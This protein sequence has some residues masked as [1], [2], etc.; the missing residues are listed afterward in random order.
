MFDVRPGEGSRA[1]RASGALFAILAGYTISETARDS[2]FLAT[3][4]AKQLALAYLAIAAIA[5]LALLANGWVVRRL[6]RRSA[7]IVTLLVAATGTS[8]FYVLPRTASAG[9]ALY[10]WTGL[11][12]TI[13]VVQ[14]WLLASTRFTSAEAKRLYGLIA[15][16]GAVGTLAG[17]LLAW[18]LL[19]ELE[20]EGL[21]LVASVFYV[22]AAILLARDSES[23]EPRLRSADVKRK[24]A[25]A[26]AQPR[27]MY[28]RR[29]ALLTVCA[30]AVALLADWLFKSGAA[31]TF[32]TDELARFIAR[33]NG[34]VA[35][36][37]LVF[38]VIGTTWLVRRL[39]VLGMTLLLPSLM[40]LGGAATVLTAGSFLA[41][42]LMKGADASLRYSVNR[43][44]TELLWMP[45]ADR[46]RASVRE[47]LESAGTRL[48]Q[49][50]TAALLLGLA[51]LG[52]A[53]AIVVS[54]ILACIALVWTMAAGGLRR[55][56]LDQLRQSVNRRS[57]DPV[58]ELDVRAIQTVVAALSSED[59]RRVIAAID[60]LVVRGRANLI[61]PLILRHDSI[62]VQAAAL[63]A[64][65]TP[66]RTDWIPLTWRL[67]KSADPRARVLALRALARNNDQTAVVAGLCDDDPGVM[68]HGVFWSLQQGAPS[69]IRD[70]PAVTALLAESGLRG[71]QARNQLLEAIR[72]DGDARWVDV[73]LDVAVTRDVAMIERLAL[74]IE[75]VPDPR[76]TPFLMTCL[77]T[78]AVRPAVRHA[79][80]A[81][82]PLA[83]AELERS[84]ADR[85]TPTRVRL[86]IP[87]TVATFGSAAAAEILARQ[88]AGEHSGAVRYRLLRGL[89]R[90]ATQEEIIVDARILLAELR[91]HL[92]EYGRLLALAVPILADADTRESAVL[93]RGLL[94]DK[95]S[96]ASDRAFLAL[97]SLHPRENIRE[98]VRAVNGVDPR[99]RA[100]GSEFLDTLTHTAFYARPEA[101]GI[102][103]RLL[104]LG[105]DLDDRARLVRIGLDGEIP[106]TA[107][108]AVAR[109]LHE[110]DTLLS[111]CAGYYAVEL[112]TPEL[113]AAVD[114]VTAA[115]PLFAPLGIYHARQRAH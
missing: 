113:A 42:G 65:A 38:Q 58:H 105:E 88:L 3:N 45:V 53:D 67:L 103:E 30:T 98:I 16:S 41:I 111:A 80:L 68:A 18:W 74:A 11:V 37:S 93:L 34:I 46:V 102:R 72:V 20:I 112:G 21:L 49:A 36:L 15:A 35:A 9:L 89:A 23:V 115:R 55:H 54:M 78:R 100:H 85:D 5:M 63:A 6:G 28:V 2:L 97:Q 71:E 75:H 108:A 59:D 14:Y 56:Y 86:H 76:F 33:Y 96:Q 64:M 44:S 43:V 61:P 84:L 79:L 73:M 24:P 10:L 90:M 82:G 110:S 87:S 25:S 62:E 48:V 109:L 27:G 106:A 50:L 1:I 57:N 29:V 40:L 17:A 91:L 47:P 94:T 22:I 69:G 7:L 114:E 8:A 66:G 83:L 104:I 32:Q 60:I 70:N 19:L 26:T 51:T 31:A 39:G 101:V 77:P 81:I 12:G 107:A 95:I 4:G 52:L 13:V 92:E 99:A